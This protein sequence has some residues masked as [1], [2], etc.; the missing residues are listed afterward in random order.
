[1]YASLCSIRSTVVVRQNAD[2]VENA[3]RTEQKWRLSDDLADSS[4][5]PE[6]QLRTAYGQVR[7]DK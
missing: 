3:R 5:L 4:E 1:M 6:I 7:T 2:H